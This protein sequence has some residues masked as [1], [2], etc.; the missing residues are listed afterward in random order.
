MIHATMLHDENAPV[1]QLARCSF[2]ASGDVSTL[3]LRSLLISNGVSCVYPWCGDVSNLY[4]SMAV[5]LPHRFSPLLH[6]RFWFWIVTCDYCSLHFRS[7][8]TLIFF[9]QSGFNLFSLDQHVYAW[10]DVLSLLARRHSSSIMPPFH[11]RYSKG[12]SSLL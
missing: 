6:F 5:A 11:G 7:L 10:Y 4:L 8:V 3:P 2:L 1:L 12:L 9:N